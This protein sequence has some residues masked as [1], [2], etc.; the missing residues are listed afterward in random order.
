VQGQRTA[1]DTTD[2]VRTTAG[3]LARHLAGAPGMWWVLLAVLFTGVGASATSSRITAGIGTWA[4]ELVCGLAAVTCLPSRLRT[5]FR[6]DRPL[7]RAVILIEFGLLVLLA[8][9]GFGGP[10]QSVGRQ[11]FA[12][13][14][15][16]GSLVGGALLA[17]GLSA[18]VRARTGGW[19][20]DG[21]LEALLASGLLVFVGWA[22]LVH[23]SPGMGTELLIF[24]LG[25]LGLDVMVAL[26]A[27]RQLQVGDLRPPSLVPWRCLT[28][29]AGVLL[30][31][32]IAR[33]IGP[34]GGV[35]V[36]GQWVVPGVLWG[37]TLLAVAG[38]HPAAAT[39]P[40]LV[41]TPPPRLNLIRLAMVMAGMLAGPAVLV[42]EIAQGGHIHS[43]GIALGTAL[44]SCLG[45]AYLVERVEE[46][47][48]IEHLAL[49]DDLTGLPNRVLFTDRVGAAVAVTERGGEASAVMFLDL[50]RFKNINDSLGHAAGNDL[51]RL[52]AKRLRHAVREADT[53]ARLG[54]DEF[55][56]LLPRL[57]D[58]E[59]L[60][61]AAQRVL[62][63]FTEPFRIVGRNL[64]VSVSVGIAVGSANGGSVDT[65]LKNA[66][67]AMYQAKAGGRKTYRMFTPDMNT[68]ANNRLAMESS[69]HT[70]ISRGEL[71]LHYQAKVDLITGVCVGM[72]ALARW[73]HPDRGLIH[74]KEFIDLAEE[75]GLIIPLGEWALTEACVQTKAWRDAGYDLVVSVNV[76]PR[77]FHQE[78]MA[79]VVAGVLRQTGLEGHA[80]ELELTES[81]A[82]H[83]P[84]AITHTLNDIKSMG[85]SCSIDDFGTGYSGLS[86]L[87]QL[88]IDTLKIDKSFIDQ[89]AYGRD[90]G[91]IVAAVIALAHELQLTV[92]A[93]GVETPGQLEFLMVNR[94]DAMQG[95]LISEPLPASE[96]SE[97]LARVPARR[98]QDRKH[99]D[100][101]PARRPARQPAHYRKRATVR[102][103]TL[104]TANAAIDVGP[105]DS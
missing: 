79:D 88:P 58:R 49:H 29:G 60:E 41:A 7:G 3:A 46:G 100:G 59:S 19:D 73:H 86:Y 105:L 12:L 30:G 72:E 83:D 103:P 38:L 37:W 57:N 21:L 8:S 91:R 69:L 101:Q 40:G 68:Q 20:L 13:P 56:I 4:V 34:L 51:L 32:D 93:E 77:Q 16:I 45:V 50:D 84:T 25:R 102:T 14:A 10:W 94:C 48:R 85:V 62:D 89:I 15:E 53:V 31:A 104:V 47:A 35:A 44:L 28:A 1:T 81:V 98:I 78:R 71:V 23:R 52:V 74:P 92:T 18:L 65:L 22:A 95:Y 76:S 36:S 43:S 42:S 63:A 54:G 99:A 5:S 9:G 17:A 26:L 33:S 61:Q 90:E 97:F 24:G 82:L 11:A 80:L 96:F 67:A 66:D 70:A 64:F 2:R 75:T 87:A 55:T 6:R 39:E 27:F